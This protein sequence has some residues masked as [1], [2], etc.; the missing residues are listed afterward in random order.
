MEKILDIMESIANEKNLELK[1]IKETVKFTLVKTAKKVYGEKYEYEAVIDEKEKSLTLFQKVL[2]V[3]NDDNRAEDKENYITIKEAKEI[4]PLVEVND[5]LRYELSLD[6][7]GRTA[8][9]TLSKELEFYIQRL[10][11]Q[12]IFEKYKQKIGKSVY[13]PVTSVDEEENTYIEIDEIRCV[14]SRKNRI[15]GEKFKVNNVVKS[16]IKKVYIDKISKR[17]NVELSRTTPKFLEALLELE[18]PEIKDGHVLIKRCARIPGE[19]AKVALS[20]VSTNIDAV[21]ATVGTKGIRIGAVSKELKGES[22]DCIEYSSIPEIFIARALAPAV[23]SS[24]IVKPEKKDDKQIATVML[25]SDQKS[26]AIGKGGI[27]IR[28]ASMLTGYEIELIEQEKVSTDKESKA[29]PDINA[30]K[31]LFGDN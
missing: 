2:V 27:N 12:Q 3:A 5:E 22:I 15:K 19:R 31:A 18:V 20:S 11:E 7:L 9:A 30:L 14:L 28:L 23:V 24:V 21:G 17:I 1:D 13:G 6:N 10:V 26:K 25:L 8:A 4:D 16:A 29:T